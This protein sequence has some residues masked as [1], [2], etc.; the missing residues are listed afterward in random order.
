[1]LG[2]DLST[3]ILYLGSKSLFYGVVLLPHDV[4]PDAVEFIQDLRDSCFCKTS[5]KVFFDLHD[6]P[7]S[8]G[9]DPVII[10]FRS[11]RCLRFRECGFASGRAASCRQKHRIIV[12][13]ILASLLENLE[14]LFVVLLE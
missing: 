10:D 11:C 5:F 9:R 4:A 3:K 2:D 14:Q 13:C 1:M 8:L 6:S 12:V 7:D